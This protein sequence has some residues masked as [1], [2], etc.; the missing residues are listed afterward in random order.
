MIPILETVSRYFFGRVPEKWV[1]VVF[2]RHPMPL[3]FE[4]G[5]VDGMGDKTFTLA[6]L[7]VAS[8]IPARTIRYYISEG[9]LPGAGPG[10]YGRQHLDS[11]TRILNLRKESDCTLDEIR[12]VFR[13]EGRIP[14]ASFSGKVLAPEPVLWAH[15]R[16][17]EDVE[18]IVVT[19]VR[20]RRRRQILRALADFG[21]ALVVKEEE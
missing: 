16:V 2:L 3:A 9:L 20:I 10:G 18:V 6:E 8:G 12:G 5:K 17:A 7:T 14:P 4:T 19:T 21:Q 15:H 1:S 11:L 13:G